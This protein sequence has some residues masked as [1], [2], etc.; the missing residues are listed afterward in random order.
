MKTCRVCLVSKSLDDFY[1]QSRNKDNKDT[2]CKSCV[3]KYQKESYD[4]NKNPDQIK[5]RNLM[6][7]YGLSLDEYNI[8]A[9]DGCYIC[10]SYEKLCVDHDHQCCPGK[11]SCGNCVR[12][13]LCWHHNLGEAKFK[14]IQEIEKLLEYRKQYE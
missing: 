2:R 3:V 8:L 7:R 5:R 1:N 4:K 10:G 14:S 9:K 13:V 11:E 6:V 12:G